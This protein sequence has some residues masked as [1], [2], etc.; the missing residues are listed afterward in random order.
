M[1]AVCEHISGGKQLAKKVHGYKSQ[2]CQRKRAKQGKL[3][4][5]TPSS[6]GRLRSQKATLLEFK[7]ALSVS[8]CL[9]VSSFFLHEHDTFPAGGQNVSRFTRQ[10]V[11]KGKRKDEEL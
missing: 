5:S 9:F 4:A 7:A 2:R 3:A 1:Y 8:I 6:S 10:V 11:D